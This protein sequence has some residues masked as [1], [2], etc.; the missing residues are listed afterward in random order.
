MLE[1]RVMSKVDIQM[2][3]LS[4]VQNIGKIDHICVYQMWHRK[5]K[6]FQY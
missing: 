4:V 6:Q 2:L 1:K 3:N 5:K